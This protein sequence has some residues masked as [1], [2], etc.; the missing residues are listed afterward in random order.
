MYSFDGLSEV[1]VQ[2]YFPACDMNWMVG[3]KEFPFYIVGYLEKSSD[4]DAYIVYPLS[5]GNT[6]PG[7]IT[8]SF[9][10]KGRCNLVVGDKYII[11]A[12]IEEYLEGYEDKDVFRYKIDWSDYTEIVIADNYS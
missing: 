1:F 5:V 7:F 4:Y 2:E 6:R 12:K 11:G 9:V 8:P 10:S 3:T